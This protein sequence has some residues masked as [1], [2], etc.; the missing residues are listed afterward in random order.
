M[1]LRERIRRRQRSGGTTRIVR[2]YEAISPVAHL[3][4]PTGRGPVLESIL[5]YLDPVFEGR[6]PT[7]A[8]V[9][10][11]PGA[12]KSAVVSSLFTHVDRLLTNSAQVIHTSTRAQTTST[13]EFVYVDARQADSPFGVYHDVLDALVDETV[14]RQGVG[15]ETIRSRLV[16]RLRPVDRSAVVAVDHVD[17]P[18]GLD[19]GTLA[20]TLSAVDSSVALVTVGRKRPD[21]L[22][23]ELRPPEHVEV[24]AYEGHA[25]VDVLTT[26]ASAGLTQQAID[27]QQVRRIADWAEGD[28][29]DALAAL[30]GAAD[31]ADAAGRDRIRERDLTDGIA[32]VPRPST[33]LGRVTTLPKNRQLV[34]RRLIDLDEA[35]MESVDATV[36]AITDSPDV[37]LSAATVQRFLYELA[38]V[39]IVERVA[40]ADTSGAGRPPSR[41]EPRFPTLVFR[42]LYDTDHG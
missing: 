22:P 41:L 23:S 40:V 5:D 26:R 13:S 42:R 4:E 39:G 14:P 32:A 27:H 35:A 37:D 1:D 6:L 16:E 31:L 33:P 15:T 2:D 11:P 17:E 25:L 24:P 36:E 21:Q 30:F 34:L 20:D 28:A 7:D 10:G 18:G 29:H 12:G 3:E 8:H 9:W 38:E 19:A